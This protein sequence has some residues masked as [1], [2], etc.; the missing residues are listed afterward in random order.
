MVRLARVVVMVRVSAASTPGLAVRLTSAFAYS[1]VGPYPVW[2]I[3][4]RA[5]LWEG[6]Q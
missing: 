1:R 6:E 3:V 2:W 4:G 5:A